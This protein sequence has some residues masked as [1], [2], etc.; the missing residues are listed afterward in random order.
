M[1]IKSDK[2][3][4]KMS[5]ESE[6]ITP[7]EPQQIRKSENQKIISYGTSSY[8]Y[9]VRCSTEFKIFTN[10]N[11]NIVDPKNFDEQSFVEVNANEC[12]IPPN[13]FALASTVEYFKIPRSTL[14]ICLGK[15]TYAR[16]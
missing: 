1:S 4:K 10:I 11:H 15:S 6:M 13:S 14:V 16:C 5:Q 3:I 12:I 2:W 7:F 8:G 9:D